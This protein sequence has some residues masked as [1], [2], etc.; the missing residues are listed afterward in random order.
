MRRLVTMGFVGLIFCG[1]VLAGCSK[2]ASDKPQS[3]EK[4]KV[5]GEKPRA[6]ATALPSKSTN[7]APRMSRPAF[8]PAGVAPNKPERVLMKPP[9]LEAAYHT[10]SNARQK[11][12]LLYRLADDG[13]ASAVDVLGRLFH[14][15]PDAGLRENILSA[16]WV[17]DGLDKEKLPIY[18]EA[19]SADQPEQ[20]RLEAIDGLSDLEDAG[21]IPL[22]QGLLNDPSEAIREAATEAIESV[23]DSLATP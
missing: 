21:A 3:D 1:V 16:L 19:I 20:V 7:A 11:A 22:L 12:D 10:A 6:S 8:P 17:V 23:Q 9:A 14:G 13:S 5:S 18:A 15:E 4:P 2:Q